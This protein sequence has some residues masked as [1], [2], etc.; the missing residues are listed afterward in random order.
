M[1][2]FEN[3]NFERRIIQPKISG[4]KSNGIEIPS[5]NF[6]KFRYSLGAFHFTKNSG[7][8]KKRNG[9]KI[10]LENP[11]IAEFSKCKAIRLKIPVMPVEKSNR[12]KIP[13][14]NFQTIF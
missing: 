4:E 3:L 6:L 8:V 7:T 14:K 13:G 1:V 9:T 10:S 2:N 11:T 5:K 12:T